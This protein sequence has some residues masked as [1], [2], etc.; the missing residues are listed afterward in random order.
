MTRAI[1]RRR[2]LGAAL[3]GAGLGLIGCNSDEPK[4]GY[5]GFMERWD[6]RVPGSGSVLATN[7]SATRPSR[8]V[9]FARAVGNR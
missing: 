4:A 3:A 5:L 6:Q 2:L 9:T 8:L 1:S 7:V